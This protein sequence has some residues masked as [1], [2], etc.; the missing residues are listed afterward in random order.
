MSKLLRAGLF[1]LVFF[2]VDW[3]SYIHPIEHLNI[4]PW[5]PPAALEIL[6]L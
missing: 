6:F 2:A 5:N 4:T 1:S 3:L